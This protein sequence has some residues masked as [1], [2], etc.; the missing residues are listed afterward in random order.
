M[1]FTGKKVIVTGANGLVGL[2]TVKKVLDE[3]AAKVYAVDLRISDNLKFLQSQYGSDYL[4]LVQTDLT[5]LS[6]CED[7]FKEEKIDI[8]LHIAGVKGSP[9]RS[10]N[11]AGCSPK[12]MRQ[13]KTAPSLAHKTRPWK[14]P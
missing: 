12:P 14:P 13:K 7:L 1:E 11:A 6:H 3:G 4:V 2:P 8:V 5:Y 10:S 9:A